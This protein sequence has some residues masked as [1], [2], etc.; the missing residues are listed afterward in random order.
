MSYIISIREFYISM[1]VYTQQRKFMSYTCG[2]QY[3]KVLTKADSAGPT[4]GPR[5]SP[6]SHSKMAVPEEC[7][8]CPP[9][10]PSSLL[11]Y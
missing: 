10:T 2:V 5:G 4:L 7:S 11:F 8:G 9:K 6:G 3:T 1:H